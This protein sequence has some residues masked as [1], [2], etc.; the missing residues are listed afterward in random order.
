MSGLPVATSP[1]VRERA[2]PA[3]T[4]A[5]WPSPSA[6]TPRPPWP[7]WPARP[8]SACWSTRSPATPPPGG[9]T[10]SPWPCWPPWSP[11]R[12]CGGPPGLLHPRRAGPGRAARGVPGRR[13]GPAAG[14]GRAGRHRRPAGP[15]H[16]RR[17]GRRRGGPLRRARDPDRVGDGGADGGAAVAVSPW[18]TLPSVLVVVPLLWLS[19]RWYLRR[20]PAGY[21]REMAAWSRL[22]GGV[23]ETVEGG[24]TMEAL[25][26]QERRIRRT[27]DDIREQYRAERYTLYLR[28]VWYPVIEGAYLIPVA[29]AVL[30]GGLL[31]ARGLATV[32]R[33]HR[34]RPL[35]AP[36]GRP[37]RPDPVLA[38][39]P[40]DRGHG[41][42]PAARVTHVPADRRA[43]G[44][45]P[46][47]RAAGRQRRP[48]RLHRRRDVLHG[49]D[50]DLRPG[51][52]LAMVG[53]SGAGKSTLGRCWPASTCPGPARSPL[54]GSASTSCP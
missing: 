4:A 30:A 16:P 38:R 27:D 14:H 28:T 37:A 52:R 22:T 2:W 11:R 40:A 9:P 5:A 18:I 51:E 29:T 8:C 53:P 50:L 23:T 13:A 26:L 42:R 24:R 43:G 33:G 46:G 44:R 1:Q 6:C 41:L 35:H 39:S 31:R 54:A 34:G 36:A 19:T 15:F 7:G 32:G 21:L 20:A 17:R 3:A 49:V 48:L 12:W 10:A 45:R 25:R 47:R